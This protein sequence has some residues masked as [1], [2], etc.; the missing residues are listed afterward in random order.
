MTLHVRAVCSK[1]KQ[2]YTF[3]KDVQKNYVAQITW[4]YNKVR[5]RIV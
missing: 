3:F 4:S 2:K 5:V 1:F